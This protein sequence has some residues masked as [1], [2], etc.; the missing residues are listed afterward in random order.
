MKK[1]ILATAVLCAAG[2]VHAAESP[3]WNYVGVNYQDLDV[4]S[5]SVDGFGL[6]GS[7]LLG[8][9]VFLTGDF[10]QT[11]GSGMD[12]DWLSAGVGY[13]FDVSP[14]TDL[15]GAISYEDFGGDASETGYGLTAGVRSMITE[16]IEL[17]AALEHLDVV[18]TETGASVSGKYYFSDKFSVGA[19]FGSMGDIDTM[20][21]GAFLHF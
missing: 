16:S 20:S 17:G 14:T 8:E 15:Y 12:L 2:A 13:K 9:N 18:D 7:V 1:L 10:S 4:Y 19:T 11:S 6:T 3:E 21:V 5:T